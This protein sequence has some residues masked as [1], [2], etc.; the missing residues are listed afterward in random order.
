MIHINI[1]ANAKVLVIDDEFMDRFE[2][3]EFNT[4]FLMLNYPRIDLPFE[5]YDYIFL[6]HDLDVV[7]DIRPFVNWLCDGNNHSLDPHIPI[8]I[9]SL[10]PVGASWMLKRLAFDAGFTNVNVIPNAWNYIRRGG[11]NEKYE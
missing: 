2:K 1:P 9:H 3:L 4:N 11:C 10:N 7:K 5:D 8:I 6:D